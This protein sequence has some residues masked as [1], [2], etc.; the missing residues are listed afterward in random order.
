MADFDPVTTAS[1][2]A[3]AYVQGMQDQITSSKTAAQKTSTALNS[4]KSA[5]STFETALSGLSS[6]T[7]SKGMRQYTATLSDS[8]GTAS[9]AS[10]AQA[11]TY[12]FHVEQVATAH[13]IALGDLPAVPVAFGGPLLVQLGDGSSI[14]VN[15]VA[16]DADGD[17][18]LTQSEIAR[19]INQAE[20]NG[21]KVTASIMTVDGQQRLLL[22]A[23]NT[24]TDNEITLDTSGLPAGALRDAFETRQELVEAKNA[25]VWLGGQGGIRIE[26]ASNTVTAVQGVSVTFTRAMQAGD[27]PVTLTVAADSAATASNVQKFVDAYNALQKALDNLTKVNK[28]DTSSSGAFA[29]DA[30]VRALRSRLNS[31]IRQEF[32]GLSLVDLGVKAQRDGTLSLDSARLE[33]TLTANPTALE[34]FFGKSSATSGSGLLG[35]LSD[36]VQVWTKAGTGQIAS[37]QNS[38]ESIQKRLTERQARLDE[39]YENVYQRYLQQFTQLQALQSQMSQTSGLFASLGTS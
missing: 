18:T 24:G 12:S 1:Q 11:G 2:L 29:T 8:V 6:T 5:L 20:G 31:M 21:G 26:Q 28:D 9:A 17:G 3:A 32:G 33:K 34:D 19:A 13:Q 7:G 10:N 16:A 25:I 27:A 37:R 22:T 23:G 14:N 39:Q 35:A 4:L 15:L 30:G 38:V 36:Y